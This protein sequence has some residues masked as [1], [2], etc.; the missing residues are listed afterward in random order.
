MYAANTV[1]ILVNEAQ[2]G[3][4]DKTS[5]RVPKLNYILSEP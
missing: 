2:D 4:T 3:Y 1:V 5:N